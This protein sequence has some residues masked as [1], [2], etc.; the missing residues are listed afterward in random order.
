MIFTLA[1]HNLKVH[2]TWCFYCMP[3][4]TTFFWFQTNCTRCDYVWQ[5][6]VI[7]HCSIWPIVVPRS[8]IQFF[9][10]NYRGIS[11][12][13]SN[14][15]YTAKSPLYCTFPQTKYTE[16]F[17]PVLYIPPNQIQGVYFISDLKMGFPLQNTY[18]SKIDFYLRKSLVDLPVY[19]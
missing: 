8:W 14:I 11:G 3:F 18:E 7:N 15:Q 1:S 10:R 9:Q 5:T 19:L 6:N 2:N 16:K 17:L 13:H 12:D 4:T